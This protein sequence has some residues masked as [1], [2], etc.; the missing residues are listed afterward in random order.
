MIRSINNILQISLTIMTKVTTAVNTT[1]IPKLQ[2][3]LFVVNITFQN[4]L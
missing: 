2:Q 1:E 4:F 3:D